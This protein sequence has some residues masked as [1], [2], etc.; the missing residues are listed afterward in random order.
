MSLFLFLDMNETNSSV[1]H[2]FLISVNI[3]IYTLPIEYSFEVKHKFYL[4]TSSCM[5]EHSYS[6]PYNMEKF[7]VNYSQKTLLFH[8]NVNIYYH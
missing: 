5:V 3:M 2:I 8:Q 6:Y 4:V 7:T 1:L